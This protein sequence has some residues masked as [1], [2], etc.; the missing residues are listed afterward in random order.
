MF[1]PTELTIQNFLS[2]SIIL[3]CL[4]SK[5]P[6]L[7]RVIQSDSVKGKNVFFSLQA[8]LKLQ[9]VCELGISVT[10]LGLEIFRQSILSMYHYHHGYA[11]SMYLDHLSTWLQQSIVFFF[12]VNLNAKNHY[13]ATKKGSFPLLCCY[14]IS[15]ICMSVIL[16]KY[17]LD[18]LIV[19]RVATFAL[20][21]GSFLTHTIFI[22][23]LNRSCVRC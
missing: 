21:L 5:L 1:E 22:F 10:A 4:V 12:V 19:S 13:S 8:N 6:Q 17:T 9:H 18:Y 7:A 20:F 2:T 15:V 14:M 16:P 3:V 23:F 11:I